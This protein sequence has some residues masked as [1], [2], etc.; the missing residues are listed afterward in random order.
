MPEVYILIVDDL[1]N[2]LFALEIVL[3]DVGAVIIKANSGEEAL[4]HTLNYDFALAV[5]DV[6][7]PDM[8]GYELADIL[9]GDPSTSRIPIIFLTAAYADEQHA[10]QGYEKGAV[11]YI[12]K[13]L[14]PVVFLSK[15]KVFLELARYRIGLE[16]IVTE[17]TLALQEES[18]RL[19]LLVENTPDCILNIDQNGTIIFINHGSSCE[20]YIGLSIYDFFSPED[21]L[22]QQKALENVFSEGTITEFEC[23]MHLPNNDHAIWYN[24]R[25]APIMQQP[26][27][28]CMQ[29]SRDI[30]DQKKINTARLKLIKAEAENQAKSKFLA[31]MSHEIRTPMNA[32]LGYVQLLKRGGHL[33]VQQL[34]Y[35]DIIDRSGEHLLMLIDSVLDMAKI[36]AGRMT[37]APSRVSFYDLLSDLKRMFQLCAEQK[38]LLLTVQYPNELPDWLIIDANKIRQILINLLGN[39][40]KFT[41]H[42]SIV[43]RAGLVA[44]TDSQATIF[45]EVEDTGCGIEEDKLDHIFNAFEQAKAGAQHIGAGLGLAVSYEFAKMMDGIIKVSSEIDKGSLFRFEFT[46]ECSIFENRRGSQNII[47]HL[48]PNTLAPVILV[49]DDDQDNLDLL[50]QILTSIGFSTH[51]IA[52]STEVLAAIAEIK[53]SLVVMDLKMEGFNGLTLTSKIRNSELTKQLPIIMLTA[54]PSQ[55]N[56]DLAFAAGVNQFLCKPVREQHILAEIGELLKLNYEYELEVSAEPNNN[57]R[58]TPQQLNSLPPSLRSGLQQALRNGYINKINDYIKR[59]EAEDAEL[60]KHLGLMANKFDYS[61]LLTLLDAPGVSDE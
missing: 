1:P 53:P 7:M 50:G 56:R 26:I 39:A 19:G 34:N 48:A 17:R 55:A 11:D 35:L 24:H 8:N 54:S 4:A 32:V 25:L 51:L 3:A 22:L 29:I 2:N 47:K 42:G 13:P 58:L 10:F 9:L 14:N 27:M 36:E 49:I 37:L 41:E 15:V 16:Q 46:A 44:S 60:G 18:N 5:L 31:S 30:S 12:V 57:R 23:L 43:V 33:T 21:R 28:E 61:S 20:Q 45:V 38:G 40:L 52:N 59:I 6:Q